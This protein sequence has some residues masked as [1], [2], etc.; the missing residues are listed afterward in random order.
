MGVVVTRPLPEALRWAERL[1]ERGFDPLVLPLLEIAP[2]PDDSG[3]RQA[4]ARLDAYAA[5][6]FVSA[7]AVHGFF[8]AA[9]GW[10]A[11]RAWAPG[12]GTAEALRGAGV[13]AASIDAPLED[14]PQFDSESLWAQVRDQVRRDDR[15][16]IVRGADAE[17]RSQG[18]EW[19][20]QQL[21]AAGAQV[22]TVVAY[23]R[24]APAWNAEQ[25]AAA[26]RAAQDGSLWLFSS[27]E[28]VGQ[29]AQLLPG[30]DWSRAQAIATHPRIAQA[31]HALGFGAVHASRPAFEEVVASIESQR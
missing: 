4:I 18:R 28:A 2:P 12:P 1:R 21:A 29:L 6:M 31:V 22:E 26:Q 30:Q 7:N 3:L 13:P 11:P 19:L 15:V 17:G 23:Q 14:A 8:A 10:G 9:S 24:R 25:V 16:L 20:A 27:S 5:V